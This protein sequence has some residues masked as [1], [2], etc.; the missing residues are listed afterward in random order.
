[1]RVLRENLAN[2]YEL[3]N[4]LLSINSPQGQAAKSNHKVFY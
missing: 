2:F 4:F 3:D 1:M